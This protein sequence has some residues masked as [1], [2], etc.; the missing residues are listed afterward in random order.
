MNIQCR[1]QTLRSPWFLD[2]HLTAIELVLMLMQPISYCSASWRQ[3]DLALGCLFSHEMCRANRT[4]ED[5]WLCGL[6]QAYAKGS[7]YENEKETLKP[8]RE[9]VSR[10]LKKK[11]NPTEM[12]RKWT[13]GDKD[14]IIVSLVSELITICR[15]KSCSIY[16][17]PCCPLSSPSEQPLGIQLQ[18]GQWWLLKW[19]FQILQL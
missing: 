10:T 8:K 15:S 18:K 17:F 5:H 4:S 13:R 9:G 12:G 16:L 2:L 11:T 6:Q 7:H 19:F 14:L 1:V 3:I